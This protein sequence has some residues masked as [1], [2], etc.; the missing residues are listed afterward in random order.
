MAKAGDRI[1]LVHMDDP[2]PVPIGTRGTVQSVQQIGEGRGS[3]TQIDVA[4]DNG[5]TLMLSVP[6]DMYQPASE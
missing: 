6:P 4:W 1:A 5:R 2:H 3:W